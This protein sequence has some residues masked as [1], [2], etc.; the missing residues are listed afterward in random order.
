M[1]KNEVS[2]RKTIEQVRAAT[3][4]DIRRL[5]DKQSITAYSKKRAKNR[6][7]L[8]PVASAQRRHKSTSVGCG[9]S[10]FDIGFDAFNPGNAFTLPNLAEL[11]AD[12]W[13]K[14]FESTFCLV[15]AVSRSVTIE[16]GTGIG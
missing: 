2:H 13:R 8:A 9:G 10:T 16:E 14:G 7:G 5:A 15:R 11:L 6:R 12:F 4:A 1:P 3:L